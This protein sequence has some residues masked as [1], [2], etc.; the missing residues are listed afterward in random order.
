MVLASVGEECL[1][2]VKII[3]KENGSLVKEIDKEVKNKFCWDWLERTVTLTIKI[4]ETT[5]EVEK[6]I[7]TTFSNQGKTAVV[8]CE[9]RMN[10][11]GA[12]RANTSLPY[13]IARYQYRNY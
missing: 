3:T 9:N 6:L 12:S 13:F 5:K 4:S 7:R 2:M 8:S 11:I 1:K 10:W